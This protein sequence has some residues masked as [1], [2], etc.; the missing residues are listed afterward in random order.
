MDAH[1]R[2]LMA[3]KSFIEH[4]NTLAHI[5]ILGHILWIVCRFGEERIE[6]STEYDE[7]NDEEK[8]K[9]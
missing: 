2:H 7:K 4:T 3:Y 8:G 1:I 5:S 9:E 6:Q